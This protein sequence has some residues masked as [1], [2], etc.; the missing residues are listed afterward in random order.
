MMRKRQRLSLRFPVCACEQNFKARKKKRSAYEMLSDSRH[1]SFQQ[2]FEFVQPSN[3]VQLVRIACA[4]VRATGD[5]RVLQSRQAR[6]E[7][8]T[9]TACVHQMTQRPKRRFLFELHQQHTD[10]EIHPLTVAYLWILHAVR[11]QHA[12]Q[13][14]LSVQI[15]VFEVWMRWECSWTILFD[16]RT[17]TRR[18]RVRLLEQRLI[19]ASIGRAN[20]RHVNHTTQMKP[21]IATHTIRQAATHDLLDLPV[22]ATR[23]RTRTYS[24]A[25]L[26][27]VKVG[28]QSRPRDEIRIFSNLCGYRSDVI[29]VAHD[30]RIC[31]LIRISTNTHNEEGNYSFRKIVRRKRSM[32]AQPQAAVL[33]RLRA[34]KRTEQLVILVAVWQ[35]ALLLV[36]AKRS[37]DCISNTRHGIV[38]NDFRVFQ[39][40][41]CTIQQRAA[42]RACKPSTRTNM[43]R[44]LYR[45]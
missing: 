22:L 40:R 16:L 30:Q 29:H 32:T 42:H 17:I 7:E 23:T 2:F 38:L 26:D 25:L 5:I 13:R 34:P 28:E 11:I 15:L 36:F 33:L 24:L 20:R 10:N 18:A 31:A 41:H 37:V 8:P 12:R 14:S 35:R 4:C 43:L 19:H 39:T 9:Q 45:N 1:V 21:Q 27:N 44:C 3:R 6:Y